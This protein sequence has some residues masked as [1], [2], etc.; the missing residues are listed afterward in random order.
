MHFPPFL[1]L[2]VSS[3]FDSHP[4]FSLD[5]LCDELVPPKLTVEEDA[6]GDEEQLHCFVSDILSSCNLHLYPHCAP[7]G[8]DLLCP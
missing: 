7:P 1:W 5:V 2:P 6:L 8:P 3:L 4:V